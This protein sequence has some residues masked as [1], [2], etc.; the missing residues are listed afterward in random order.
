MRNRLVPRCRLT[1]LGV[2]FAHRGR[3]AWLPIR[4]GR[5]RIR[6]RGQHGLAFCGLAAS[7]LSDAALAH[8]TTAAA[9][10]AATATPPTTPAA[11]GTVG[12]L[13]TIRAH[14]AR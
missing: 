2:K 12:A 9:A 10:P 5:I 1:R 6:R 3:L 13:S 11:L 4:R 8:T 14:V 7:R